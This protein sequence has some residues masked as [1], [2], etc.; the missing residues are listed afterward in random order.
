MPTS[1]RTHYDTLQVLQTANQDDIRNAYRRL[2][3]RY[4]PDKCPDDLKTA[5]MM[6]RVNQAYEILSDPKTRKDHDLWIAQRKSQHQLSAPDMTMSVN[7]RAMREYSN[8]S[9]LARNTVIKFTP[10]VRPFNA[11]S[12]PLHVVE[13]SRPGQPDAAEQHGYF[14]G[15][16]GSI[17]E[18]AT[19]PHERRLRDQDLS[20]AL[21]SC[22]ALMVIGF[23][24][25]TIG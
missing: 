2:A 6:V 3:S 8:V 24:I 1:H 19:A 22:L 21:I 18:K 17:S 4:H 20:R 7:H 23:V 14:T 11:F 16:Y 12:R 5:N 13:D 9:G 25:L 10:E 15:R